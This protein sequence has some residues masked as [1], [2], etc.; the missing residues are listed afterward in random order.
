MALAFSGDAAFSMVVQRVG[1]GRTE[2]WGDGQIEKECVWER[3]RV[4]VC[5]CERERERERAR[6]EGGREGER[7]EGQRD[8]RLAILW[9][10]CKAVTCTTVTDVGLIYLTCTETTG[11]QSNAI[12]IGLLVFQNAGNVWVLHMCVCVCVCVCVCRVPMV[13]VEFH[14]RNWHLWDCLVMGVIVYVFVHLTFC[15][16]I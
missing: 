16:T 3:E 11:S 9:L 14:L 6:R 5:V 4:C 8:T 10:S 2:F 15:I 7:R 1:R 12:C 13:T